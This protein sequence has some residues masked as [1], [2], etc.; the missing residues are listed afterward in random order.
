MKILTRVEIATGENPEQIGWKITDFVGNDVTPYFAPGYYTFPG[1][2][3]QDFLLES[4]IYVF[5]MNDLRGVGTG[6]LCAT[7]CDCNDI[8]PVSNLY[9]RKAVSSFQP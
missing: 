5:I 3:S 7:I 2:Y 9:V 8:V 6:K 4:G 1:F